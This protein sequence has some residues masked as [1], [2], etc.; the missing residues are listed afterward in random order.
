MV[1]LPP[2]GFIFSFPEAKI[3]ARN[4]ITCL[5]LASSVSSPRVA[6]FSRLLAA[7]GDSCGGRCCQPLSKP[8]KQTPRQCGDSSDA[9]GERPQ[10]LRVSLCH[11][12]ELFPS[13]SLR[14][15]S[16]PSHPISLPS[17][18]ALS[19]TSGAHSQCNTRCTDEW[20]RVRG[21][22]MVPSVVY[23]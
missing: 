9:A 20:S 17:P 6:C 3:N 1:P 8:K 4:S 18:P 10:P 7:A 13:P 16:T 22:S 2:S 14:E 5:G 19:R 11:L 12:E 21:T 23:I 15:F